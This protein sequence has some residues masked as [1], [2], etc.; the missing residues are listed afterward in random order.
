MQAMTTQTQESRSVPIGAKVTPS[1]KRAIDMVATYEGK[2]VADLLRPTIEELVARGEK[3]RE[4][5][6]EIAPAA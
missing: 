6:R 5:L 2:P 3:L 1:E 4:Q